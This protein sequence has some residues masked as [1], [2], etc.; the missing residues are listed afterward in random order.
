DTSSEPTTTARVPTLCPKTW[1]WFYTTGELQNHVHVFGHRV[2]TRAV[3]VGSE[4]VSWS[5]VLTLRHAGARTVLM[6]S[7]RPAPDTYAAVSLA[8][9]IA[10]GVPVAA[11][12][13]VERVIGKGRV[14]GVEVLDHATGRTR[15]VA[16]DCVVFTADWIPDNELAVQL[17]LELQPRSLAPLVD[18]ALRTGLPGVFAAGNLLHPVDTA[19]NAA[20]DGRHV[21]ASV[22]AWLAG[23]EQPPSGVQLRARAPLTWI[24]PGVVRPGDPAPVGRRL[25]AWTSEYRRFPTLEAS[26]DGRVVGRV[27]TPWPAAPGRVFRIPFALFDGVEHGGPPVEVGFVD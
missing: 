23:R 6:A 9:R 7:P 11:A 21:A 13:T 22:R 8:G 27:R 18:T 20:L 25:S 5:A 3:V 19:D 2:G 1:T 14:E 24:A 4:L 26:Q 15:V 17:G 10:F 12:T 16:C